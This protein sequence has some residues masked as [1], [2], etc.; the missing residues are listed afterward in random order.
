V[1]IREVTTY[2]PNAPFDGYGVWVV[3]EQRYHKVCLLHPVTLSKLNLEEYEYV[4]A[5]GNSL[6]PF[7]NT[8]TSF[9]VERFLKNFKERI[10]FFIDNEKSIPA[11]LCATVI[12]ELQ[13]ISMEGARRII[14]ELGLESEE[15]VIYSLDKKDRKFNLRENANYEKVRGRPLAII[16][17]LREHGP[18]S[19][20]KITELVD[21]K[22]KTRCKL[23]RAV[24][25]FVNKLTSQGILEIVA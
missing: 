19:M 16:E 1:E 15:E 14:N 7:N 12:S 8:N 4:R 5:S 22:L 3:F 24:T 21:G 25:Y 9:N 6:W 18:A 10:K 11:E 23:S 17:A 13:D 2:N 20:K